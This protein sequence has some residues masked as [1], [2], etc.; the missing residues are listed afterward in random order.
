MPSYMLSTSD[1]PYNPFKDWD[2]WFAFD[3]QNGYNSCSYLA[4]MCDA[5]ADASPED[6]EKSVNDAIDRIVALNLTGNYI[7]VDPD[8]VPKP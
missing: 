4:R 6:E 1:N 2:L 3:T 7:K 5:Y 8:F